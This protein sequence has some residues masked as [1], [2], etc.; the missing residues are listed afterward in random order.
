MVASTCRTIQ[1]T[2]ATHLDIGRTI[3]ITTIS[4]PQTTTGYA[5]NAKDA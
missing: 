3:R 1:V 4:H 2:T 5:P